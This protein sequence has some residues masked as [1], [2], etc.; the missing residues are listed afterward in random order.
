MW[1]NTL[2]GVELQQLAMTSD[3]IDLRQIG[4]RVLLRRRELGLEQR[5]VAARIGKDRGYVSRLENAQISNPKIGDLRAIARALGVTLDELLS[6]QES[7]RLP[8]EEEAELQYLLSM[9]QLAPE[10]AAFV[11]GQ[12]DATLKERR[13]LLHALRIIAG[14]HGLDQER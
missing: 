1:Y 6:E 9:R 14:R 4:N 12:Q 13:W 2:G 8:D 11:K 10:F 3:D 7:N 5:D